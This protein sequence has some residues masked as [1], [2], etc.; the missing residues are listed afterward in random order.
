MVRRLEP[1]LGVGN[2]HLDGPAIRRPLHLGLPD[3]VPAVVIP[4][5]VV[6]RAVVQRTAG[7]YA[8]VHAGPAVVVGV[9]EEGEPVRGGAAVAARQLGHHGIGGGIV[10]ARGD[11]DGVVVVED[12]GL[13]GHR[14]RHSLLRLALDEPRERNRRLPGGLGRT[15]VKRDPA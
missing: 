8:E 5:V 1:E 10:Q 4:L 12:V 7:A 2:A 11:V 13:G 3:R 6:E 15:A 14:G 9:E